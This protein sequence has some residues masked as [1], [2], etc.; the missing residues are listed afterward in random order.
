[1]PVEQVRDRT[2]G[3]GRDLD[4]GDRSRVGR[5]RLV[6]QTSMLPIGYPRSMLS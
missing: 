4:A 1:M 3:G 6:F 2:V 5:E